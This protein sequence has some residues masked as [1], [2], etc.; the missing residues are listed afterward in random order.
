MFPKKVL[1]PIA[2]TP[3]N[4][5]ILLHSFFLLRRGITTKQ[6]SGIALH[7]GQAGRGEVLSGKA[8]NGGANTSCDFGGR[9]STNS[10]ERGLQNQF[11]S[12]RKWDWSCLCPFPL[13]KIKMTG[14][15]QTGGKTY[16]RWGVQKSKTVFGDGFYVVFSPPLSLFFSDLGQCNTNLQQGRAAWRWSC[17]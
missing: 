3:R 9:K 12:L 14:R 2:L 5:K 13:T 8:A 1:P 17:R 6:P 15:E 11:W 4:R 7:K 10:T 16:R